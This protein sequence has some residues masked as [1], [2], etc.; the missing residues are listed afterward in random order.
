[1]ALLADWL[2]VVDV[3]NRSAARQWLDVIG[4]RRCGYSW[5]KLRGTKSTEWFLLR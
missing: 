5:W 2:Q 4:D 3:V 1:V